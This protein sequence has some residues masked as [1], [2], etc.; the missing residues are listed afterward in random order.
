[1]KKNIIKAV[2]G[3]SVLVGILILQREF[4]DN[5]YVQEVAMSTGYLG[6]VIFTVFNSFNYFVP[7]V[8]P[9]LVPTWAGADLNPVVVTMLI[10]LVIT[11]TDLAFYSLGRFSRRLTE[12]IKAQKYIVRMRALRDR[13]WYLPLG[14]F[15]VWL[16]VV[17]LPNELIAIPLGILGYKLLPVASIALIGNAIFNGVIAYNALKLVG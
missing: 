6:V 17:P 16:L 12:S 1:M 2:V 8:T 9:S 10:I 15:A 7:I 4:A 5:A 11:M 3:L 14:F 13:N